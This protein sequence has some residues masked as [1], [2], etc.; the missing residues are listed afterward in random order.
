[1]YN[2][3]CVLLL[4][5]EV[6]NI[7]DR[8]KRSNMC[9]DIQSSWFSRL[10]IIKMSIL[11]KQILRFRLSTT[12][13]CYYPQTR[14]NK[15]ISSFQISVKKKKKIILGERLHIRRSIFRY[16]NIDTATC[17]SAKTESGKE[18]PGSFFLIDP[19]SSPASTPTNQIQSEVE[20]K[21]PV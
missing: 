14:R 2:E 1:M 18:I 21:G 15:E 10:S 8:N 5:R 20:D 12:G 7:I 17:G 13:I 6:E 16:R 4:F 3:R 9:R 11:S 19:L